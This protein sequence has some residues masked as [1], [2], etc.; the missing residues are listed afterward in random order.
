MTP[1]PPSQPEGS[2]LPPR[3]RPT[4][5]NLDSDTTDSGFWDLDETDDVA[6][7]PARAKVE[8]RHSP[9]TPTPA[10][11]SK[12]KNPAKSAT[13]PVQSLPSKATLI[14]RMSSVERFR[15][16][17]EDRNQ[18][19]AAAADSP[20]T[21]AGNDGTEAAFDE[22]EQW[23]VP[24][25]P[26]PAGSPPE[27][28]FEGFADHPEVGPQPGPPPSREEPAS[29]AA[30]A[31]TPTPPRQPPTP[32]PASSDNEFAPAAINPDAKPWSW[33][34]QQK[35]TL[36]EIIGIAC[37]TFILL[38]GG[39]WVFQQT[40]SRISRANVGEAKVVYPVRGSHLTI[41]KLVTYWRAPVTT[42]DQR[43]IVRRGVVL[44]PVV[45]LTVSGGPGAV[46]VLFN[47]EQGKKSGDPITRAVNGETTLVI[48]ATDG[49][50]DISMHA[51]YRTNLSKPWV[52]Q[53]SEAASEN[54]PG[55]EFKALL[56]TPISPE[57][58]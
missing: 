3:H 6:P 44:I 43:E 21:P 12:S 4:K 11:T 45:E 5:D 7:P 36:V 15:S 26:P 56:K 31:T 20:D 37:L 16:S 10:E 18:H 13:D 58:R 30:P 42:G 40:L 32:P 52:I 38:A 54:A 17:R 55:V 41:T 39:F 29:R 57:K 22:L 1:P 53:V 51:A 50:E 34:P 9:S 23:A 33:R 24:T 25:A 14:R 19:A 49:F 48:P 35:L 8:P 46:R 47:N 28:V 27:D 2:S